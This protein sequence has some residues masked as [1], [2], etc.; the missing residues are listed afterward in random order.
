MDPQ[1]PKE[2]TSGVC[3]K[4]PHRQVWP[5]EL[6]VDI[7]GIKR[8]RLQLLIY[9]EVSDEPAALVRTNHAQEVVEVVR[10]EGVSAYKDAGEPTP[11]ERER[12]LNETGK[13]LQLCTL[14]PPNLTDGQMWLVRMPWC[15][16][17]VIETGRFENGAISVQAPGKASPFGVGDVSHWYLRLTVFHTVE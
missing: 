17:T 1:N 8:D 4:S 3:R 14:P 13:D 15:G 7:Y 2:E 12:D 11:F 6:S 16:T 10:R 5:L 9:D